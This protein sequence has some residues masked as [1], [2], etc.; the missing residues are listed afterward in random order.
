MT[1]SKGPTISLARL[2]REQEI[3]TIDLRTLQK[4]ADRYAAETAKL[5]PK[6]YSAEFVQQRRA[7]LRQDAL[8]VV[9]PLLGEMRERA[10][11]ARQAREIWTPARRRLSAS[12]E[13]PVTAAALSSRLALAAVRELPRL[14]SEAAEKGDWVL[15]DAVHC[16]TGRLDNQNPEMVGIARELERV[17]DGMGADTVATVHQNEQAVGGAYAAARW[18]VGEVTGHPLTPQQKL[19]IGHEYPTLLTSDVVPG[20]TRDHAA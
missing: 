17:L 19:T 12:L 9:E 13:D 15:A 5:D 10:D 16:Q 2:R 4:A 11:L 3:Q 1:T 6:T 20:A 8:R 14:A 18:L 7:E